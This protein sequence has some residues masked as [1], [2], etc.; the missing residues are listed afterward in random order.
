MLNMAGSYANDSTAHNNNQMPKSHLHASAVDGV[1]L[2]QLITLPL[3][4]TQSMRVNGT[5]F[6]PPG[7]P[8]RLPMWVQPPVTLTPATVDTGAMPDYRVRYISQSH[9][10]PTP[11]PWSFPGLAL[12]FWNLGGAMGMGGSPQIHSFV[13]RSITDNECQSNTCSNS[14][15]NTQAVVDFGTPGARYFSNLQVEYR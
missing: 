2:R 11:T 4:N 8:P 7:Q 13:L 14:Y 12:T 1:A 9:P 5:M 15:F 3:F 10:A 6:T